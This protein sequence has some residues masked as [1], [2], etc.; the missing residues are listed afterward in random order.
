MRRFGMEHPSEGAKQKYL[1]EHPHADPSNHT[2]RDEH[3]KRVQEVPKGT[4]RDSATFHQN[5]A[6]PSLRGMFHTPLTPITRDNESRVMK[7]KPAQDLRDSFLRLSPD[8]QKS[9]LQDSY[10]YM[11]GIQQKAKK[12]EQSGGDPDPVLDKAFKQAHAVWAVLRSAKP[13][14]QASLIRIAKRILN[15]ARPPL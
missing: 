9:T 4:Y 15:L 2:V 1:K 10:D 6:P 7:T 3:T 14:K 11:M 13:A 5:V 12:I 8:K